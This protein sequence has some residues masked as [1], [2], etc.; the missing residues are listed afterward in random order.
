[1]SLFLPQDVEALHWTSQTTILHVADVHIGLE[2]VVLH[3]QAEV[4][5]LVWPDHG[6]C[7]SI[8]MLT[9]DDITA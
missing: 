1:M 2:Q 3:G 5:T 9:G 7:T 6:M 8:K 4:L